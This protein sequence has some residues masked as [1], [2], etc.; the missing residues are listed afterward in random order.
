M[1]IGSFGTFFF[2]ELSRRRRGTASDQKVYS[3][4][5]VRVV[6]F[7]ALSFASSTDPRR[8][9]STSQKKVPK[10]PIFI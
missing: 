5:K 7:R 1:N 3:E 6:S 10:F 4:T 9:R 8:Q 2:Q